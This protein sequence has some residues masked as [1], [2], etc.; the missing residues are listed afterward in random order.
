MN[1]SVA[2]EC[3]LERMDSSIVLPRVLHC[4]TRFIGILQQAK[5]VLPERIGWHR[6]YPNT[7][8]MWFQ[9]AS[10]LSASRPARANFF[11]PSSRYSGS[12]SF[13]SICLA[14]PLGF[15]KASLISAYW[16]S[17]SLAS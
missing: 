17:R 6:C 2:A 3:A 7:R 10:N 15:P 1:C 11:N 5:Q 4:L 8:P 9:P 14:A 12:A 13:T 16:S